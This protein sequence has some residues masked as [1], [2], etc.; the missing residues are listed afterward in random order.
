MAAAQTSPVTRAHSS[1]ASPKFSA[2][3]PVRQASPTTLKAGI[4]TPASPDTSKNVPLDAEDQDIPEIG[5]H[6][7]LPEPPIDPAPVKTRKRMSKTLKWKVGCTWQLELSSEDGARD[8]FD[9]INHPPLTEHLQK[10]L[11]ARLLASPHTLVET[12]YEILASEL[13]VVMEGSRVVNGLN[14]N[15]YHNENGYVS[16]WTDGKRYYMIPKRKRQG[17]GDKA[18]GGAA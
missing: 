14:N 11:E 16:V 10:L 18:Q 7:D 12:T 5:D 4:S 2:A 6:C 13:S 3:A 9:S 1:M 8:A 17:G 15:L